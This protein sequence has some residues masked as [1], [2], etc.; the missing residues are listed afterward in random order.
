MSKVE[1]IA[2]LL[3]IVTG[4]LM[5]FFITYHFIITHTSEGALEYL[6]V[7]KRFPALSLFYVILLIT[8]CF[9]AFNGLRSILLD[10][11]VNRSAVN[12]LTSILMIASIGVGLYIISL[13]S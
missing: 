1:P 3:Q 13:F 5:V 7:A 2:W 6:S 8:V 12:I 4:I 11:N 9:H 10:M